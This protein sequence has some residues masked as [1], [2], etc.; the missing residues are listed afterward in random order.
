MLQALHAGQSVFVNN[1]FFLYLLYLFVEHFE[2]FGEEGL[3]KV[4]VALAV[5]LVQV[6]NLGMIVG[7]VGLVLGMEFCQN[8]PRLVFGIHFGVDI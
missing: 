3:L 1:D 4:E 8:Q 2:Y 6:Y 7:E 5:L